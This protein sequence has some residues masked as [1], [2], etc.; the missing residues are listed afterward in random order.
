MK[1]LFDP[2]RPRRPAA[3]H[4]ANNAARRGAWLLLPAL[5]APAM[6]SEPAAG[7]TPPGTL[8]L[9]EAT[10]PQ[11]EV[12]GHYDTAVGS[13]DAASQGSVS[14]TLLQDIA[15]LRPGEVLETVPGLVVTQHSGDGKANQ[16]FLRGY[17]LDHGTDFATRIDGV[18]VNLPSNAH[19]QGY[20]DLNYLIP[21]L[22]DRIDYVKGP[23]FANEGDFSSAGAASIR[24]RSTLDQPF[25]AVTLGQ[26]GYRRLLI[27]GSAAGSAPIVMGGPALLGALELE[28]DD[29]PWTVPEGLKKINGL[30]RGSGGTAQQGWS[31]EAAY[32][33]AN[34]KSTDQVP[35]SLLE[36]GALP[37]FSGLNPSDGGSTGRQILAA[38]W[39]GNDAS[40]YTR[41]AAYFQRYRLQLFSDFT[42]F[43]LRPSTGDQFDQREDRAYFGGSVV[44]GWDQ[45]LLGHET[46]TE[47]G[48]QL[49]H[50]QIHVGLFNTAERVVFET[51]TD[52]VVQQ[53]QLG[54]YV[55][56]STAWS[57]WLRTLAGLRDERIVLN[58]DARVLPQNSGRASAGLVL[59]KLSIILGPWEQSE[60]FLNAGRG[61]HSNDARGV[62]ATVDATTGQSA[63]RVAPLVSSVGR[64]LGVRT[65]AIAGW[66]SSLALWTLNSGSELVYNADSSIGSTSPNGASRRQGVEWNNHFK[67]GRHVLLDAD[68]AWTR[69]RYAR[70]NDNGQAGDAIPNAVGRVA[71]LRAT[72]HELGP[73]TAAAE[74][75]VIGSYPLS[76]DRRLSAPGSVVSNLRLQHE[77]SAQSDGGGLT[78]SLDVLNVF[79][80]SYYD[81]AY[82]QD[83]RV[84]PASPAIRAGVTVHPGEPRQFRL[85][86]RLRF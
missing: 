48:L 78:L 79:N 22:V 40:G 67:G 13:S 12:T 59:P 69:A 35:L 9:A 70:D 51:V 61:L 15:L 26:E 58:R 5:L 4:T 34:W 29:G 81:I 46:T 37:R 72:F 41:T 71:M 14:G 57:T 76:Q 17:N 39:H 32:Y 8:E 73:W 52:D 82:E 54:V 86:A 77:A 18:P 80:R 85:T 43:E 47:A 62:T 84:T 27:A 45:T 49:R 56:N 7:P 66:Q 3:A 23:Y 25:A 21:E 55:Q 1:L 28:H 16:Y 44:R 83:Y 36:S 38:E 10:L 19:G 24:Y 64:E 63:S 65:E 68:L 42:F 20:C 50:D 74:T 75:R 6:G 33:A 60:L 53:S 11:I 31:A 30:L 2:R